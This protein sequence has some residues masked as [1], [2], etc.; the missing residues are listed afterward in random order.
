MDG[1]GTIIFLLIAAAISIMNNKAQKKAKEEAAR[2]RQQTPTQAP[3]QPPLQN[4]LEDFMKNILGEQ[5]AS[6]KIPYDEE[7]EEETYDEEEEPRVEPILDAVPEPQPVKMSSPMADVASEGTL[8]PQYNIPQ[9]D[10]P[11]AVSDYDYNQLDVPI[12]EFDYNSLEISNIKPLPDPISQSEAQVASKAESPV[13]GF[14]PVKAIIYSE[15][16]T[17]KYI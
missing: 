16:I 9:I 13:D 1:I 5:P 2:R 14:D 3:A 12:E 8:Y 11:D 17:P 6:P 4:T 7:V 10:T 15:I